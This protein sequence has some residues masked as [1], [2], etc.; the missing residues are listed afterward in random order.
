M[1]VTGKLVLG[2]AGNGALAS[3]MASHDTPL[4]GCTVRL[5]VATGHPEMRDLASDPTVSA[6]VVDCDVAARANIVVESLAAGKT[7]VCSFPPSDTPEGLAGVERALASGGT[8]SI[9][10]ELAALAVS[11]DALSALRAGSF[12]VPHSLYVSA[13]LARCES[14]RGILDDIGWQVLDLVLA[15]ADDLPERVYATGGRLFADA[16]ADDTLT[17]VM[18]FP[19]NLVVTVEMSRC[20]PATLA[21]PSDAEMEVEIICSDGALRFEPNIASNRVYTSNSASIRPWP[22]ERIQPL[23]GE[24]IEIAERGCDPAA[25]LLAV[26][27]ALRV[28]AAIHASK[29]SGEAVELSAEKDDPALRTTHA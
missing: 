17:V 9:W 27:R 6:I 10:H 13:R 7:V 19:R 26:R 5:P 2:V 20:L 3:G 12:G 14:L 16:G 4:R 28:R 18:R 1:S 23:I 8:L 25:D 21:R 11:R 24:I 29:A 15:I 22:D